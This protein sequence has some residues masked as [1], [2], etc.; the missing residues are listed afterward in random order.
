MEI[1]NLE[2]YNVNDVSEFVMGNIDAVIVV[3]ATID[4]YR[5]IVRRNFFEKFLNE[6]GSYHDLI[7]NLW[8]H[9]NDSGEKI[10][11]DR[12]NHG[13]QTDAC[14]DGLAGMADH[15][16]VREADDHLEQLLNEQRDD[17]SLQQG[18]GKDLFFFR[19]LLLRFCETQQ[20]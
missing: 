17:H 16:G 9:F 3:D 19:D 13:V 10:N 5:S 4:K 14:H 18:V 1:K 7:L 20:V 8:F 15:H 2:D 12:I 11:E 6:S